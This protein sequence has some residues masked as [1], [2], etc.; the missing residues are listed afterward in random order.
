MTLTGRFKTGK[1]DRRVTTGWSE[2]SCTD[3]RA[4]GFEVEITIL[5]AMDEAFCFSGVLLYRVD[6]PRG[7]SFFAGDA[8][9]GD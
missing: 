2:G 5:V 3:A 8:L 7:A 9:V 6:E 1:L 4:F